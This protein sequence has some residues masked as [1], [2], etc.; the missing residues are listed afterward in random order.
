MAANRPDVW[1]GVALNADPND[2]NNS[3]LWIDLTSSLRKI[4]GLER[5]RNF[6]LDQPMASE[7]QVVI[8][9]VDEILNPANL[10]SAQ[11]NLVQPYRAQC[12]LAQWPNTPVGGSV[13]L[14]NTSAW[15]GNK[16]DPRDGSFESF[17]TGGRP[18]WV[19]SVG[20]PATPPAVG[21]TTPFQGSKD[22]TWTVAATGVSQGVSWPVACIPGR[23]YTTSVYVRQ[24]SAST[25]R[26][27]VADQVV[28][29]D[30]F[31]V[32]ASNGWG[33]DY[34]GTA[35]SVLSGA[36]SIFSK[37]A[38]AAVIALDTNGAD[39]N[40]ALN[41][42]TPDGT[43]RLRLVAPDPALVGSS[44]VTAGLTVRGN[45]A[46]NHYDPRVVFRPD[47]TVG[48]ATFKR[49]AGAGSTVTAEVA[50]G[51]GYKPGD[52]FVLETIYFNTGT[53]AN[54]SST[55]WPVTK[56][57]PLQP[58]NLSTDASLLTGNEVGVVGRTDS[59]SGITFP[60]ACRF[61]S[62]NVVGYVHGSTTAATGAYNRISVT[63]T[64]T[65]PVH[66]VQLATTGTAVAG[67][68][69]ADAIQHEQA[70]AASTYTTT[71]PAIYPVMRN[72]VEQWPRTWSSAGFEGFVDAPCVDGMA[73]LQAISLETEYA[74]A[75]LD[76][77][78]DIYWRLNDGTDTGLFADTSG[79]AAPPLARYVS[80][81]GAGTDVEPGTQIE[82]AGNPAGTGV[83][84]TQSGAVGSGQAAGTCLGTMAISWP[85]TIS[86]GGNWAMSFACWATAQNIPAALQAL[87]SWTRDGAASGQIVGLWFEVG[88]FANQ[89]ELALS[90]PVSSLSVFTAAV[91]QVFDGN[92]HHFAFTISVAG[93]NATLTVWV[94]GVSATNTA[95]IGGWPSGTAPLR[96]M[97]LGMDTAGLTGY[98]WN[99]VI[100]DA[101][102][103]SRALTN[104]EITTLFLAGQIGYNGETTGGRILRRLT[105]NNRYVGATR[106]TQETPATPQT[107]LQAPSWT[108]TKDLLTDSLETANAEQGT[109]WVA[110]DGAVVFESRQDRWLRLTPSFVLGE[111]TA[112]GEAPYLMDGA[113]FVPDPL[114]VY[115]NVQIGRINGAMA[116]GGTAQDIAIASR[117]YF[118]RSVQASFDFYTDALAQSMANWIFNTHDA[119][120][121]RIDELVVDPSSNPALWPFVLGLEIG[122]RCTVKRRAKAANSG[123]GITMSA[124]YF[125]EKI[126]ID[127]ID[128]DSGEW[129]YRIQ[130]SPI[131][132]SAPA[133]QPTFQPW[134]LGDATYGVLGS[135]TVLGW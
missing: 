16:E 93:A 109:F 92:A 52:E 70:A 69:L 5:G 30:P 134:I 68:V 40:I 73:A 85:P 123:A 46:G 83:Q 17:A 71:G 114:F 29:N 120:V 112:G 20:P 107:G 115:A 76:T 59:S 65:Q 33:S 86:A 87:L 94:D 23:Q 2:P 31:N 84:F 63:W 132:A 66:T 41:T 118:P 89:F 47:G 53:T 97:T 19:A 7:P 108:D 49:V 121:M 32:T 98:E 95:G 15:K 37:G 1:F 42:G 21:T 39:R 126:S 28:A 99:G 122:Q 82:Y 24:S 100:S 103:W 106:I 64:A 128:F 90:S 131:N 36:S 80:K 54:V 113:R 51:W 119:P 60:F 45:G 26:I 81:F 25:Q 104:A 91:P 88:A 133:G 35:W 116:Q 11:V 62:F 125:V 105:D 77:G 110:P 111:D 74:Q 124:D 135:T 48:L 55:V 79:N 9:D 38:L 18:S 130:L 127:V 4:S 8:R 61:T 12:M 58:Q 14:F 75:V 43:A 34:K 44:G 3:P 57:K 72:L 129:T 13:N 101:A 27:S 78:P 56:P 22:L 67:T 50:T 6:E 117:R 96:Y 102:V 10:S